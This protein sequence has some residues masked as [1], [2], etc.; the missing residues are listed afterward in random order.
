MP[1]QKQAFL[2]IPSNDA[3]ETPHERRN[4]GPKI[5]DVE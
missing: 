2:A 5:D 3:H 4:E 1:S